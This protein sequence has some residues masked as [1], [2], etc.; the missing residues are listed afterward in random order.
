MKIF[1]Q[2]IYILSVWILA[3]NKPI[4]LKCIFSLQRKAKEWTDGN[5]FIIL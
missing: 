3:Y 2:G 5:N 1:F 4:I